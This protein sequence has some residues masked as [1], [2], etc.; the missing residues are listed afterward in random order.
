MSGSG[1][2]K[3][4][5]VLKR[6]LGRGREEWLHLEMMSGPDSKEK[7]FLWAPLRRGATEFDN[8]EK[9]KKRARLWRKAGCDVVLVKVLAPKKSTKDLLLKDAR[10]VLVAV[11]GQGRTEGLFTLGRMNDEK[12]A[13]ALFDRIGE[14]VR[15]I[16][17]L[18]Y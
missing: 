12:R 15:R 4:P 1:E 14:I 10:A 7:W 17:A 2:R 11:T 5:W 3:G 16:D 13:V 9:A 18:N 8:L 6:L